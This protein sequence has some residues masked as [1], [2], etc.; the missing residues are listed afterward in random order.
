MTN[1]AASDDDTCARCILYGTK[2]R[3]TPTI[4]TCTR[5]PRT[6]GSQRRCSAA[7]PKHSKFRPAFPRL[8][9]VVITVVTSITIRDRIAVLETEK[10]ANPL[11]GTV[12]LMRHLTR[13]HAM[14]QTV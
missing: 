1:C 2:K 6:L 3:N 11:N 9:V 8:T 7:M 12:T 10:N 14:A 5:K 4:E 13:N